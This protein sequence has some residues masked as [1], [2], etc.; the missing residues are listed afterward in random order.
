M[1]RKYAVARRADNYAW[2]VAKIRKGIQQLLA[3]G[4]V[5][6]DVW[7]MTLDAARTEWG[8]KIICRQP[9][10]LRIDGHDYQWPMGR[11]DDADD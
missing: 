10:V 4:A 7:N 3:D 8:C 6:E 11:R 9:L 1:T 5:L 2:H